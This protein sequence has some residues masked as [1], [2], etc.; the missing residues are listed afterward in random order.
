MSLEGNSFL[1][2]NGYF[3]MFFCIFENLIDILFLDF[4][5]RL[6]LY[7]LVAKV[8]F[9]SSPF[10]FLKGD[11]SLFRNIEWESFYIFIL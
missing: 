11:L 4:L 8:L 5:L 9:L 10:A 2:E 3:P 1:L 6:V 7:K